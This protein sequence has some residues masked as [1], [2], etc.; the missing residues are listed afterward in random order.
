MRHVTQDI[1]RPGFLI[2]PNPAFPHAP[3]DWSREEAEAM[4]R[5]E[6]LALTPD[7]WRVVWALQEFF[8]RHEDITLNPRELHDALDE[9]FHGEGGIRYLYT[10]FPRGPVAQ[11]CRLAGLRPPSGA[12]DQGFG[13]AV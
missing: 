11:G 9:Y 13:S 12:Q 10:L 7:H 8:A 1:E 6:G 3:S 2:P 4:A 5:R